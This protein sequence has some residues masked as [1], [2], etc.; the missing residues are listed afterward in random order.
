LGTGAA[1]RPNIVSEVSDAAPDLTD[2]GFESQV[3]RAF[4]DLYCKDGRTWSQTQWL[5]VQV[6]K[7]PLDLWI[8]QEILF[9]PESRPDVIIETG[10]HHGGSALFLASMCDMIGSGRVIT[11]ELLEKET[12]EHPRITYLTGS[13]VSPEI[14]TTVKESIQS[15]ERV[16]VLLDSDHRAQH[17]LAELEAYS[18]LVTPGNYLIVED[19]N[20]NSW[21]D[22]ARGQ[23]IGPGPLEA[24]R[25]FMSGNSDFAVD[26][27]KERFYMTFNPNGYLVRKSP[28][29]LT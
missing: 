8:Y 12:P 10:T 25:E 28:E 18:P 27:S 22:P 21:R 24:V 7:C 4:H 11:I 6:I 26:R 15:N 1:D 13:S 16:M 2:V 5:G 23:K 3:V 20:L 9:A 14:L 17:V 19:T 29:I